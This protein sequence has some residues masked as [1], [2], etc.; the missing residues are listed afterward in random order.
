M[1]WWRLLYLLWDDYCRSCMWLLC[2]TQY[3]TFE[4]A[5]GYSHSL[6]SHGWVIPPVC[7]EIPLLLCRRTP[8][9]SHLLA[10]LNNV[11]INTCIKISFWNSASSSFRQWN[12]CYSIVVGSKMQVSIFLGCM[13]V[14]EDCFLA[15]QLLCLVWA[16]SRTALSVTQ[17]LG[18]RCHHSCR[19]TGRNSLICRQ[20]HAQGPWFWEFWDDMEITE[21]IFQVPS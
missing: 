9:C 8:A 10:V 1:L 2:F 15:S 4:V 7:M 11:A 18:L 3:N 5:L 16:H 14:H 21:N 6:W 17:E 13:E 19:T 20:N 12:G